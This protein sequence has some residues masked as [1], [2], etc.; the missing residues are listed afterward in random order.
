MGYRD[1]PIRIREKEIPTLLHLLKGSNAVRVAS[2]FT[3]LAA[4]D[5][6]KEDNFTKAQLEQLIE[7]DQLLVQGLGYRPLK[8]ALN[9]AG[10]MRFPQYA[11]DMVRVGIGLYGISP[12]GQERDFGLET[13]ATLHTQILQV[14][15]LGPGETVGYG[16]R[17]RISTPSRIGVIPLGYADGISRQLGNGKMTFLTEHGV[18]V[19]TIGNI[20]MD[21]LM[22]DL[23]LDPK[24]VAGSKVTIF[25]PTLPITR[26]AD[27]CETIPYEIL[28]RLSK[29]IT[30]KYFTE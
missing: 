12:I 30:R 20:C 14:R 13:V 10:I 21:T 3:H 5:D 7:I 18:L 19:P 23:T 27:A 28:S 1:A 9:T 11:W 29:R 22:I 4:A 26:I 8:H 15:D 16:R 6:P 24:A 25:G 2:H 17:G